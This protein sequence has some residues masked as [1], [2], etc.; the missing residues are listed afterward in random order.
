MASF[1]RQGADPQLLFFHG[2][3]FPKPGIPG[4]ENAVTGLIPSPSIPWKRK[5]LGRHEASG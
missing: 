1:R 2:L 3:F 5:Y 4:A